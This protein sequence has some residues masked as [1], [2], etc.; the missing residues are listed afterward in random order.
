MPTAID[1]AARLDAVAEATLEVALS[2]GVDAVTIRAVATRMGGST[3]V[4][5]KF[6][7]TRAELLDNVIR[8]VQERWEGEIS[9]EVAPKSGG[10]RV[11]ALIRWSTRPTRS[12][13]LI[14]RFWLNALATDDERSRAAVRGEARRE[15]AR[16]RTAVDGAGKDPWF[17]DLIYLAL[18]GYYVST[19]EDPQRWSHRK[20]AS[21]LENLLDAAGK[22]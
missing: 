20:V 18:R 19:I 13:R 2:E 6:V 14:R 1:R 9:E 10:D 7:P 15:H 16:I 21:A 17:A 5:T 3:T 12:D 11:R 22:G 4:I 8:Y